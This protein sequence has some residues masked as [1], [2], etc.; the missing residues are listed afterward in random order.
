MAQQE[1]FK[2]NHTFQS[3]EFANGICSFHHIFYTFFCFRK[4][5]YAPCDLTTL[6]TNWATMKGMVPMM[7]GLPTINYIPP[8]PLTVPTAQHIMLHLHP[9]LIQHILKR[10]LRLQETELVRK[11]LEHSDY[12]QPHAHLWIPGLRPLP[13]VW[14]VVLLAGVRQ[15][16]LR[17]SGRGRRRGG[18]RRGR[19]MGGS[20]R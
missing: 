9:I 16:P 15:D 20:T 8:L 19:E 14:F 10:P 5:I 1:K 2:F 6:L 18:S 13:R 3:I 17:G 4:L 7:R 11:I 12:L